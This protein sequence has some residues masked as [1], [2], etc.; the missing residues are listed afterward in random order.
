MVRIFF[1]EKE[2]RNYVVPR[3]SRA[4]YDEDF[5]EA[6]RAMMNGTYPA[7]LVRTARER[8]GDAAAELV[9]LVLTPNANLNARRALALISLFNDYRDLP[10]FSSVIR[11]ALERRI[12]SAAYLKT[13]F[14]DERKQRPFAFVHVPSDEGRAMTRD[15]SYY[16]S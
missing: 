8:F 15:I 10:L 4:F 3:K 11:E 2:I 9:T 16:L 6:S 7:Y 1:L 14:D 12:T 13:R 5:P